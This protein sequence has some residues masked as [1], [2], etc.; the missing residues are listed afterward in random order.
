[1][2]TTAMAFAT[3]MAV[4]AESTRQPSI[5]FANNGGIEN[6][7]AD[8]DQGLWIQD[9]QRQW[10][11]ATFFG[12]CTGLG[13][14]TSLAFDTRPLGAFDRGSSIIV[15]REGRCAVRTFD[16]SDGPPNS[17]RANG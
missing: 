15:P 2:L 16:L 9:R 4:T 10:Y 1:M 13:F 17:R 3:E 8:S 12:S 11:Y 5:S 7:Q 6:W 14:A